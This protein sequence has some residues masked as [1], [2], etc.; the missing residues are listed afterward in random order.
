VN[1]KACAIM[2]KLSK[3]S[4]VQYHANRAASSTSSQIHFWKTPIA[5][6]GNGQKNCMGGDSRSGSRPGRNLKG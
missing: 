2:D 4:C 3:G 1:S 5:D 6:C